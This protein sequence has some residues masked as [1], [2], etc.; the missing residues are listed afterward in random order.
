MQVKTI[1]NRL[2]KQP[3][4]VY[5][6]VRFGEEAGRLHLEV[7][8][9]PRANRQPRCAGCQRPGPGYEMSSGIGIFRGR[10]V[11]GSWFFRFN[12][13]YRNNTFCFRSVY[14]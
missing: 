14:T 11:V 12:L 3:G 2:Q 13:W 8:L 10:P 7:D 1:L 4:F 5:G 6:A 9:R